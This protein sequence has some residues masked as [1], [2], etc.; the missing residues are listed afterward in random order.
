MNF[1][2]MLVYEII[3][4]AMGLFFASYLISKWIKKRKNRTTER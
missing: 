3:W 4:I 1:D 2:F